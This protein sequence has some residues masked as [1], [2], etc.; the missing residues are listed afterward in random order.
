ML[1][2]MPEW[3]TQHKSSGREIR[4]IKG[5]YYLYQVRC[6]WNKERKRPQK[7]TEAFLGRI[8]ETGVVKGARQTQRPTPTPLPPMWVK[9]S[10]IAEFLLADNQDVLTLLKT[11]FSSYESLFCAAVNRLAHQ[12]P[13]K[14]MEHYYQN[15]YLSTLLPHAQMSDKELTTLLKE[16]GSQRPKISDFMHDFMD[17]T[18]KK[19]SF[20]LL[21]AT[22]IL[23]LSAT[24]A[25][26]QVGY[27]AHGS[28][29][30]QVSILYLF[31]SNAKLPAYYRVVPGNIKE[32]TAMTLTL[33]ESLI[34]DAV[35][36]ADKGFFSS[37]NIKLLQEKQ[38]RYI[39]PLRRSS[40]LIDYNTHQIEGRKGFTNYLRYNDRIIWYKENIVSL[41]NQNQRVILFLDEDLQRNEQRDYLQRIENQIENYTLEGYHE[42][43]KKH[44]TIALMTNLDN[45]KTPQQIYEQ[46][47]SRTDIEVL[48]DTFRNVLHA[49]V[50]Y[51]RSNEAMQTWLFI[52]HIALIFYYRI[53]NRL[54]KHDLL[55]KYSPQDI[56]NH[57]ANIKKI[58]INGN[59]VNAEVASK[60]KK[61][62][63]KI[64]ITMA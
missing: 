34:K 17:A 16:V 1:S 44:G 22:Q 56:L 45:K 41:N 8:T 7:I 23:S 9:T 35:V 36:V 3:V 24:L 6:V 21:D 46:Y 64:K 13:L 20:L 51:M 2:K 55:K 29:D 62:L 4:C 18:L 58:S 40:A 25:D 57:L 42:K 10:G 30:P 28:H 61:I 38:L 14:N 39:I 33:E 12:S 53:Y 31:A 15:S 26:A 63:Q 59:W 60:S 19:D 54:K 48:F 27:N 43:A 47:K 5:N 50:T 37:A 52:N 11:H 49:D 32:V